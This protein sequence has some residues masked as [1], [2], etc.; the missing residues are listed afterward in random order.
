MKKITRILTLFLLINVQAGA[1]NA[2]KPVAAPTDQD[3]PVIY[4]PEKLVLITTNLG[5]MK[6]KLYNLTPKHRDNFLK[7]VDQKFYDSLLFHRVIRNFM[8]QGGDP[9]SKNAAPG[10]GLGNGDIGYTIP[11]EFVDTLYHKKGALCAARTENPAKASSGCQFYI[12][13]GQV[14]TPEQINMMETQRGLKLSEAQKKAYTTVGGSPWLDGS[15]TVYGEVV[16]GLDIIDK[17]A[18][19]KTAP[20]DRPVENVYILKMKLLN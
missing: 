19:V 5:N 18:T 4:T 16:E 13:Q 6:V 12:V 15:Y 2:E 3:K 9:L 10:V 7:L 1:Q 20:G 14:M 17:I 8:I 11:A